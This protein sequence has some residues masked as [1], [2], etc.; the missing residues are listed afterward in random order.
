MIG[1]TL[2]KYKIDG[3]S[4]AQFE[5]SK[6]HPSIRVDKSL[7]LDGSTNL[8]RDDCL[9]HIKEN[10]GPE[11]YNKL[12][13]D[14]EEIQFLTNNEYRSCAIPCTISDDDFLLVIRLR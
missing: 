12:T 5:T 13:K 2:K 7:I 1:E 4:D 14:K 10:A 6:K 3:V 11:L 9:K 8:N